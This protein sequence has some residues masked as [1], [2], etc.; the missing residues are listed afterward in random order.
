MK[1]NSFLK[2]TVVENASELAFQ[3]LTDHQRDRLDFIW[4]L[5]S[6]KEMGFFY[7]VARFIQDS[8]LSVDMCLE[9]ISIL[10]QW[11][12][13]YEEWKEVLSKMGFET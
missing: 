9:A 8:P 7:V 1:K 5:A 4:K 13:E 12:G 11:D 10:R 6:K 3:G 2:N